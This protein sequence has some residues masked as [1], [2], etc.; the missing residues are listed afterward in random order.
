MR[1]VYRKKQIGYNFWGVRSDIKWADG[2]ATKARGLA[3]GF[4]EVPAAVCR[5]APVAAHLSALMAGCRPVRAVVCPPVPAAD[6][7]QVRAAVC[8]RGPVVVYPQ[9]LVVVFLPGLAEAC[10]PDLVE[11]C[12]RGQHPI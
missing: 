11:E 3:V 1:L 6:Y 12:R 2:R 8:P 5:P 7:P 9:V 10:R 4:R